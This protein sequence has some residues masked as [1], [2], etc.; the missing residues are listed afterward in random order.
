MGLRRVEK[1]KQDQI[2]EVYISNPIPDSFEWHK[3]TGYRHLH[4]LWKTYP[5]AYQR[6]KKKVPPYIRLKIEQ[7]EKEEEIAGSQSKDR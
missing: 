7:E 1:Q 2:K 3:A 4:E 5:E 6:I